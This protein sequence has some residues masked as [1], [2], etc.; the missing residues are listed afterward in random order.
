MT[1]VRVLLADKPSKATEKL[2]A[3]L[4]KRKLKVELAGDAHAALAKY[5]RSTPDVVVIGQGLEGPAF[6]LCKFLRAHD[7]AAVLLAVAKDAKSHKAAERAGADAT[8]D[9]PVDPR[10]LEASVRPLALLRTMR[11]AQAHAGGPIF[12]PLTGFYAFEHFKQALF[13]EVKRAR[14]Y[15]VPIAVIL[16]SITA[17]GEDEEPG[18]RQ[19]L[20]GGLALAVRSATRDTD[21]PVAYG[22]HN[23]MILLP[24]TSAEGAEAVGRRILFK[25]AR[26]TLKHDGR[27]LKTRISLGLAA[28]AGDSEHPFSELVHQGTLRLKEAEARGG[29]CLVS[30]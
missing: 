21:L 16:S 2:A 23:V 12:D 28:T 7:P 1:Q 26:S 13:V 18:L 22:Q 10:L 8:L 5:A 19:E 24:H 25:I 27:R 20:M 9:K 30:K 14:R 11:L 3:D 6:A 15:K 17:H 29:N 4:R